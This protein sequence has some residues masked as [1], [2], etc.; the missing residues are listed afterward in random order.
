MGKSDSE[1]DEVKCHVAA[2]QLHHLAA[3]TTGMVQWCL[4]HVLLLHRCNG[5]AV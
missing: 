3:N 4:A 1:Y 2:M 5:S